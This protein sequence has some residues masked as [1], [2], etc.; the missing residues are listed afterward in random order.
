M[1]CPHCSSRQTEKRNKK[2]VQ[3]YQ[4]YF[5][6]SCHRQYNERTGSP[7]NR[8]KLPSDVLYTVVLWRLRYKLSLRDL[9]EMF[10][11]RG[12]VFSHEAVRDWEA[13]FAP[14]ITDELKKRRTGKAGLRWRV[15][16]T[17]IKIGTKLHYLYRAIDTDG[18]L[19]DVRISA[20]RD[21]AAARAFF[22]QAVTTVGHK[23]TQV[24]S[25]KEASYPKASKQNWAEKWKHRTTKYLNNK[26]EQDHRGVK[27]R[28]YPMLSFKNAESADRFVR[29]YEEQRALFR[30]RRKH[31]D[32]VSLPLR[33]VHSLGKFEEL[34]E[35]FVNKKM[36][37]R[38]MPLPI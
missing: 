20:I 6:H 32:T 27:Q 30:F 13:K 1:D 24:T 28:Y 9:A 17:L 34:R 37:W 21:M 3:G 23:P 25:D 8:I 12:F 15:D 2:T 11:Q 18:N 31:K 33:R 10:L 38:Q 7:Y 14:L 35:I 22:R 19:V 29:A 16:E 36:V 5:C 26:L 4:I